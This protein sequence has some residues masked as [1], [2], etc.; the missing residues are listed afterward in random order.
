MKIKYILTFL[1][2]VLGMQNYIYAQ[3]TKTMY[4]YKGGGGN[5][6]IH[7]WYDI[8]LGYTVPITGACSMISQT[9]AN[10]GIYSENVKPDAVINNIQSNVTRVIVPQSGF[11]TYS[12]NET[13][14]D[15]YCFI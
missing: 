8:N 5:N 6:G 2:S 3:F 10:Q 12:V 11:V 14:V 13:A 4:N 15:D 9:G 1:F 7:F